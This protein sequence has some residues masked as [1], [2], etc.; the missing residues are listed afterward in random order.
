MLSLSVSRA[1]AFAVVAFA[2][3]LGAYGCSDDG[4]HYGPPD[5]LTGKQ[6]P[7]PTFADA[8]A[9]PTDAGPIIDAGPCAVSWSTD[10]FPNMMST[11]AWRCAQSSCH[12]GFQAPK[13]SD[14]PAVTYAALTGYT[15]VPPAP[16]IP[17]VL[18]GNTDPTASGIECNLSGSTCGQQMPLTQN[19]ASHLTSDEIAKL[20]TWV[21]CGAPE[22]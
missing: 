7:Q 2:I 1:C 4:P 5:G 9:R 11:G 17:Y 16:S 19:G 13:M 22:N 6:I 18:P 10:I 8:S 3:V 20:D 14:D 12:G 21:K 15:M